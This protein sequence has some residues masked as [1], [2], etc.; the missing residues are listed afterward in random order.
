VGSVEIDFK[1]YTARR[2]DSALTMTPKEFEVLK[3]LWQHRNHVVSR[4][5]LLT[6]V[7]GYDESLSTRTIDNFILK[8]RQAIEDNP[9]KPRVIITVHGLG[10]KLIA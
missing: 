1:S 3:F 7:W 2:G 5:Q 4:D 10:Y 8:L 9:S 6:D